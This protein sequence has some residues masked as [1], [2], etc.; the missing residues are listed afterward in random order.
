MDELENNLKAFFAAKILA[1]LGFIFAN[2]GI[3]FL[4]MVIVISSLGAVMLV[5]SFVSGS[6]GADIY[7]EQITS[8]EDYKIVMSTIDS[9]ESR[10]PPVEVNRT[11]I[12][13][14]LLNYNAFLDNE[15]MEEAEFIDL[16]D[17]DEFTF[18]IPRRQLE[19]QTEELAVNQVGEREILYCVKTIEEELDVQTQSFWFL[20][21]TTVTREI[22]V[23]ISHRN[24]CSDGELVVEVEYFRVPYSEYEEY[25]IEEF[26]PDKM[27]GSSYDDLS[28][29][30]KKNVEEIAELALGLEQSLTGE[31]YRAKVLPF[32]SRGSRRFADTDMPSNIQ[33]QLMFPLENPRRAGCFGYYT[34]PQRSPDSDFRCRCVSGSMRYTHYGTDYGGPI[35]TPIYA[36]ADGYVHSRTAV[37]MSRNGGNCRVGPNPPSCNDDGM[38]GAGNSIILTHDLG[39]DKV[40]YSSYVHLN[41]FS[42]KLAGAIDENNPIFVEQGEK[43][44]YLGNTGNSSGAHL[45]FEFGYMVGSTRF[46]YN[47][48]P[49]SNVNNVGISGSECNQIRFNCNTIAN[50]CYSGI[51]AS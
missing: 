28:L 32:G 13:S 1:L 51:E 31:V 14:L 36:V 38:H 9:V 25:V 19:N 49:L 7:N 5:V 43:V 24:E 29:E 47:T 37:D 20:N 35:G 46:L 8:S 34:S 2:I 15:D 40:Y 48:E 39:D 42:S 44:G 16:D 17:N 21:T 22:T 11:W 10:Y 30:E 33:S 50:A 26:L 12:V 6:T 18:G 41:E 3:I 4:V 23:R 45:H 27:Y